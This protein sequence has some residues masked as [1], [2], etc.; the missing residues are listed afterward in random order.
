MTD[1]KDL[2][3]AALNN[4]GYIMGLNSGDVIEFNSETAA[5]VS[6]RIR[7]ISNNIYDTCSTVKTITSQTRDFWTG[8]A[9]ESFIFKCEEL[10]ESTDVFYQKLEA[11][12]KNIEL[13]AQSLV[14]GD[15]SVKNKVEQL[16]TTDIF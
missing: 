2:M 16:S 5:E 15:T 11:D 6:N 12:R 4:V 1:T 14:S 10:M 9:A 7:R 8:K 3:N 13:A